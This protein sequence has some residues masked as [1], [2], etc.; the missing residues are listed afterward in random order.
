MHRDTRSIT[1]ALVLVFTAALALSACS[2]SMP[3]A[4]SDP[5]VQPPEAEGPL[6]EVRS[7]SEPPAS[8]SEPA[9]GAPGSAVSPEEGSSTAS[10]PFDCESLLTPVVMGFGSDWEKRAHLDCYIALTNAA[11]GLEIGV[12]S[13][14]SPPD[15]DG[16][17]SLDSA[18][19]AITDVRSVT[20]H[21]SGGPYQ[22]AMFYLPPEKTGAEWWGPTPMVLAVAGSEGMVSVQC[23]TAHPARNKDEGEEAQLLVDTRC[24]DILST[25]RFGDLGLPV[26]PAVSAHANTLLPFHSDL[27]G[28]SFSYPANLAEPEVTHVGIPAVK[29]DL[30]NGELVISSKDALDGK[31]GAEL[32][33]E[34]IEENTKASSGRMISTDL[35]R[36][37][38]GGQE[39]WAV[40]RYFASAAGRTDSVMYIVLTEG[41]EYRVSCA[42]KQGPPV[43]PWEAVAPV[44]E[45]IL[46]T[47]QFERR[48]YWNGTVVVRVLPDEPVVDLTRQTI[49][50]LPGASVEVK[51]ANLRVTADEQGVARLALPLGQ[52]E[53]FGQ[54]EGVYTFVVTAP[55]RGYQTAVRRRI[56]TAEP[57]F[58]IHYSP[59]R[60]VSLDYAAAPAP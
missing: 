13:F 50:P 36:Q 46:D 35:G 6:S 15:S 25:V 10:S 60:D 48:G 59:Q 21:G 5:A 30:V 44:C 38:L 37:A 18:Y 49:P 41:L 42:T 31:S 58:E 20:L 8:S 33:A 32:I 11:E 12:S 56:T 51:E 34:N 52:T 43:V 19:P 39:A 40:Q 23:G 29:L 28:V 24:P 22:A 53:G 47:I 26:P 2:S 7:T 4:A 14:M 45:R 3:G 16:R 57:Q 54:D 17:W 1:R 9:A 27:V 55:D